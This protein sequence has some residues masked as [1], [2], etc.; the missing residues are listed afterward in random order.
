MSRSVERFTDYLCFSAAV[1]NPSPNP[2]PNP[3]PNP[4][5]SLSPNPKQDLE[6]HAEWMRA[7]GPGKPARHAL[8]PVVW[9]PGQA[10]VST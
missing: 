8:L 5:P 6:S 3:N 1:F 7:I 10:Q 9:P 4:K 2:N